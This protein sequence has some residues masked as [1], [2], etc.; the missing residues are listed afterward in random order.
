MEA[1]WCPTSSRQFPVSGGDGG[2]AHTDGSR[3]PRATLAKAAKAP[4][5]RRACRSCRN[6]FGPLTQG[7]RVVVGVQSV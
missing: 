2:G 7:S 1:T 5:A 3:A 4:R 6:L